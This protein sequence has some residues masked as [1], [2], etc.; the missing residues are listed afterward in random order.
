MSSPGHARIPDHEADLSSLETAAGEAEVASTAAPGGDTGTMAPEPTAVDAT[1]AAPVTTTLP[2]IPPPPGTPR[3]PVPGSL[4]EEI[5]AFAKVC[6]RREIFN[7]RWDNL[8][9][10]GGILLSV[11]IIAAGVYEWSKGAAILGGLV[12]AIVTAQRAFPF[13]QRYMFYRNLV[14]QAQMLLVHA[15]CDA[16]SL[17]GALEAYA[18][19]QLDFAQ[20]L[21]RG[22]TFTELKEKPE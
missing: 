17:D 3:L 21:P 19:L 10:I 12:A 5:A 11:V 20:Q 6:E 18:K 8:L 2:L 9:N 4:I 14:G 16:I 15:R 13:N 1:A 22:S 7:R